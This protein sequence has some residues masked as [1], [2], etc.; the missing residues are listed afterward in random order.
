MSFEQDKYI[1]VQNVL[2]I[3]TLELLKIQIK[4][5]ETVLNN[6]NNSLP[7]DFLFND[8][9][10]KESFSFY[11][12]LFSEALLVLLQPMIEQ[13]TGKKLLPTYSYVRIYYKNAI[14]KRHTD[15]N[16][17]EYSAT[18][19]IKNDK[20]PWDFWIKNIHNKDISISLKE[21]DLII[22]KGNELEHWREKYNNNEHIQFF[23]HYVDSDGINS[24]WKYDKR[25]SLGCQINNK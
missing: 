17:C 25:K 7:S 15:R 19:C 12:P 4:M 23:L 18:I 11:S 1:I 3:E 9:Q 20:E 10:I 5:L 21:G 13:R 14:L 16:S 24:D 2:N 6:N 8:N 22:Y